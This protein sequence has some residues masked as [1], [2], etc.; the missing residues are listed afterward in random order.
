VLQLLV[1]LEQYPKM[2][3]VALRFGGVDNGDNPFAV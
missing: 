1:N 2:G 3:L